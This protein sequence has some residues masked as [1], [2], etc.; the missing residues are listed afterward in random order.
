MSV[1]LA[2]CSQC[3]Y[4]V[5][6]E[7]ELVGRALHLAAIAWGAEV[8]IQHNAEPGMDHQITISLPHD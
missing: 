6:K 2:R 1:V 3:G 4:I 5:T 8:E 7:F